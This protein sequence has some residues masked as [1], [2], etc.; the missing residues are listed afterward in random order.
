MAIA[1]GLD[2]EGRSAFRNADQGTGPVCDWREA[3]GAP[4]AKKDGV[5]G[6]GPPHRPFRSDAFEGRTGQALPDLTHTFADRAG[7]QRWFGIFLFRGPE[8][9]SARDRAP[10]RPQA[11]P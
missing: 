2:R 6:T 3:S 8:A 11:F 7:F 10:D 1:R 9:A 5:G 4:F